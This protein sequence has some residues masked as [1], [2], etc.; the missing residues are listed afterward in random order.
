[1][2]VAGLKTVE[3]SVWRKCAAIYLEKMWLGQGELDRRLVAKFSSSP[4]T[5][6]MLRDL[7]SPAKYG[8]ART[9]PGHGPQKYLKF[10]DMLNH[11]QD[12]VMT[13]VNVPDIIEQE[14][15][16]MRKAYGKGFPS[17]ISKA[18]WMMK[19]H[20]V[21]IYDSFAWNGL[22]RLGLAPGSDYRTYFNSWFKFFDKNDTQYG[23]ADALSWL[24]CSPVA[25]SLIQAGR[26]DA[27]EI[28]RLAASQLFRNRV[29]DI[30]LYCA[31]GGTL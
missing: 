7:C 10:A 11:Y 17:A 1:L 6:E 29:T 20:P 23:L 31:G 8:V 25:S 22:Q 5:C 27:S 13:R 28:Q 26:V 24:P 9:V 30:H 12:T 15:A 2:H 21:V 14:L 18:L 19:Q 3:A 16:S 4:V